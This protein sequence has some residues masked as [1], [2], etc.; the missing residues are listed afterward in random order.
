MKSVEPM[1]GRLILALV[2]VGVI[3]GQTTTVTLTVD[4]PRPLAVA[5]D[6][7]EEL[8]GIAANYEDGP[9]VDAADL[10]D[11]ANEVLTPSQRAQ[12]GPAFQLIVPRGGPLSAT[13][14]VDANDSKIG[15]FGGAQDAALAFVSAQK[16][17]YGQAFGVELGNNVLLVYPQTLNDKDGR[18]QPV[19]PVLSARISIPRAERT[20]FETLRLILQA[21]SL[22]AGSNVGI[23]TIPIRTFAISNVTVGSDN[24]TARSVLIRLF[25]A[26]I[27]NN[28]ANAPLV[29]PT[30]SYRLFYDANLKDYALN[31]QMLRGALIPDVVLPSSPPPPPPDPGKSPF[32]RKVHP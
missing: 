4:D 27:S 2:S 15:S 25:Q 17:A 6:K 10:K 3:G 7:I 24:E 29:A 23:G 14:S 16:S 9:Y 18:S 19:I 5:C 1:T 21:V 11:V 28:G 30:L 22:A 32:F 26:M 8:S 12:A 13:V 31:V 20:A